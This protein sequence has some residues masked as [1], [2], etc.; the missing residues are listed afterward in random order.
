MTK[1]EELKKRIEEDP[2]FINMPRCEDSLNVF[3]KKYPDG[4]K[5]N[6]VISKALMISEEELK[7]RFDDILEDIRD[8]L[9][10]EDLP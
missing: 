1:N 9:N 3:E 4:A 2:D 7:R 8:K 5:N 10:I 6:E